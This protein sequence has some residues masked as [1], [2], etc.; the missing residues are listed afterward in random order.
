MLPL[1]FFLK[2]SHLIKTI[3]TNRG[4]PD[5]PWIHPNGTEFWFMYSRYNYYP[6]IF[7]GGVDDP[8]FNGGI[9]PGHHVNDSNPWADSDIYYSVKTGNSWGIPINW[10]GNDYLEDACAMKV[11]AFGDFSTRIYYNKDFGDN[12]Q[13][14]CYSEWNGSSWGAPTRLGITH[15]PGSHDQNPHVY[16]DHTVCVYTSN[17][18]GGYG[19]NDLWISTR[20]ANGWWTTPT[21]LG[22]TINTALNEDQYFIHQGL[23]QIIF[24]RESNF[25]STWYNSNTGQFATPTLI[26][27]KDEY[28][29]SM[30]YVGE[31][32]MTDDGLQLYFAQPMPPDKLVIKYCTRPN[33]SASWSNAAFID[34]PLDEN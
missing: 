12:G 20:E 8:V 32:S 29:N 6:W 4:W 26:D 11:D 33:T 13:E 19:G 34:L 24:N 17:R 7:S 16:N 25:Y 28:G 14:I 3:N 21:N 31:A 5:S 9:R 2:K 22:N 27:I 10:G 15:E 18:S 23:N 1:T 30:P